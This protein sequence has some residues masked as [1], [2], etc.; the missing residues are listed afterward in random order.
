MSKDNDSRPPIGSGHAGA[1]FR[2]GLRE[3]RAAFYPESKLAQHSEYGLYGT[4]TPGEVAADRQSDERDLD[5]EPQQPSVL[6][7]LNRGMEQ[8]REEREMER[9]EPEMD[10]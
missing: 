8:T 5:E 3:L 7:G 10:R 6:D 1:M 4:K 9:E 2:L